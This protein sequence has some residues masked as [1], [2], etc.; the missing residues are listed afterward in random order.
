MD[1]RLQ[2]IIEEERERV[3]RLN[4]ELKAAKKRLRKLEQA[5]ALTTIKHDDAV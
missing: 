5:S 3:N 4:Q 1:Q 2:V